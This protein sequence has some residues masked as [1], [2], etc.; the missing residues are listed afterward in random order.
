MSALAAV[1][2]LSQATHYDCDPRALF[3]IV[4]IAALIAIALSFADELALA[5]RRRRNGDTSD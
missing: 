3:L 4:T 5:P 2:A 1:I